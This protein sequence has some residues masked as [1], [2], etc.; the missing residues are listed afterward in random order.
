MSKVMLRCMGFLRREPVLTIAAVLAL[1]SA[2]LVP[3][4]PAYL[5]YIDWETLAQ[6][7]SL[8]AVVQGFQKAGTFLYLGNRLLEHTATVRAMLFV[9]VLL[10]FLSSMVITNDVA[11]LTFVPFGLTVLSLVRQE[12]QAVWLVALQTAAANLGSMLTPMG[13]PQNLYLYAQSGIRFGAF[14]GLMLPYV[15]LSAAVLS[16]LILRVKNAPVD[17]VSVAV[18]PGSHQYFFWCAVGLL[19]CLLGIFGVL[20]PVGIA[21]AVAVFLVCFDRGLLARIDYALLGTFAAF[22]IFVGNLAQLEGFRALLARILAGHVELA[23]ILSSQVLSNVPTALLLSGF[24][25]QWEALIVGCN[26]GGLGTL[27]ASMASLISY[28]ALSNAYPGQRRP[29]LVSF[30]GV[31]LL[32]LGLLFLLSLALNP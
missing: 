17:R 27:I 5:T 2:V 29:Y 26:L 13:N 6:L 31:N 16:V 22:F 23:A 9:L 11:L 7:F 14:C 24:T 30:T 32:L 19:L 28:K 3:P 8:M 12:R 20:P 1:A 10:P 25:T 21:G 4:S 18:H 15:L